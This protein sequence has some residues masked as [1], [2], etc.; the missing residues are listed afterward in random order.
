[1][2]ELYP[3][4]FAHRLPSGLYLLV[5]PMDRVRSVALGV[6]VRA[7]SRDD[8]RDKCGLAHLLEHMTFRGT[9]N[10]TA[11][12]IAQAI[13]SLGG[14]L[15]GATGKESTFYYTTVL[16]EGLPIA[17]E[18][19]GEMLTQPL[20]S[21]Q[22]LERERAVILEE[23][24]GA[25]DDPQEV[26]LRLLFAQLWTEGHPLGRPILGTAGAV[27][28]LGPDDV[29]GFFQRY[30]QPAH[31]ILAASGRIRPELLVEKALRI[32]PAEVDGE[33]PPREA[34]P[35]GQGLVVGEKD[36]QQVHLALGFPTL[37]AGAEERYGLEVLST[38]LGGGVSSR[39]FQRVREERGLV[40]TVLTSTAYYTD[41][42]AL[43]VYAATEER[44][45]AEVLELVWEEL[46]RIVFAPPEPAEVT[47]VVDRLRGSFLLGLED[48]AGRMFRLGTNAA[49][50]REILPIPEVERRLKS[51]TPAEVQGLARRFLRQD[52]AVLAL[53][54]PSG[55]RL[56]KLA[57]A[58]VEVA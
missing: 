44:R 37:G 52:R 39:L 13:D 54:G 3:G 41:A 4:L 8:P 23:I 22:D 1:M 32:W 47:R 58:Q 31:M 14:N 55:E 28:G 21:P 2:Q 5:E 50:G 12:E 27:A 15:N 29:R 45:L 25:E 33:P 56:R 38:L 26:V 24:R 49:L 51:V 9:A 16:E 48:P 43:V 34:P 46:R 10:R 11:L 19:L 7:G 6:W 20:L 17:L 36:I 40:Y 42:G 30:Y 57:R 53:V 18:V 35:L